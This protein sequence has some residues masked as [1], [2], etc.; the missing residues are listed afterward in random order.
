VKA[1]SMTFNPTKPHDTSP[2]KTPQQHHEQAAEHFEQAAKS[3]KE[4]AK[5]VGVNDHTAAQPH[6]K[7]AHEH[8][9]KAQDH[10]V[11]AGK[12]PT[13]VTK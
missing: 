1:I 5:L 2:A 3:H 12:K 7:A 8:A 13:P 4:V 9:A 10:V 6:V 11:E